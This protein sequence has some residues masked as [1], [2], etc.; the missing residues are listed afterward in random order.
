MDKSE[1]K[2]IKIEAE[3]EIADYLDSLE[4]FAIV[5]ALTQSLSS[6]KINYVN[7]TFV[8]NERDIKVDSA[9]HSNTS[10]Y[11]NQITVKITTNN[12][13]NSTSGTIFEEEVQRIISIN[14]CLVDIEPTGKMILLSNSDVPGVIGNVGTLLATEGINISDFRLGRNKDGALAV[15]IVDEEVKSNTL[16]KLANIEAARSVSYAQI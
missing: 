2:S 5:G 3:G 10:A 1:I 4:T 16:E 12:G 6:D 13:V 15:I 7:A 14:N 11:K 9:V 8:A